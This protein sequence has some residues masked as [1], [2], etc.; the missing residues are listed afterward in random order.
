M[1]LLPDPKAVPT[2]VFGAR[3]CGVRGFLIFDRVYLGQKFPDPYYAAAREATVFV[4]M[5][6]TNS[7]TSPAP[8][9][10]T[11]T[12]YFGVPACPARN[13][14]PIGPFGP[15]PCAAA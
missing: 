5:S 3:P 6:S 12:R 1:Q 4:T 7:S 8:R 10:S 13:A 14:R 2:V 11:A 15:T 9:D